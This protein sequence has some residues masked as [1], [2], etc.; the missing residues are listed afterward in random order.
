M[1]NSPPDRI[2]M[3]GRPGQFDVGQENL[4]KMDGRQ[5]RIKDVNI[6]YLQALML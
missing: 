5:A 4:Q 3:S 2:E 6:T 1:K